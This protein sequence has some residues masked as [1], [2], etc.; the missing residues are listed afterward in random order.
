MKTRAR[1]V[2]GVLVLGLGIWAEAAI[3][4]ANE[5]PRPPLLG[6]LSTIPLSLGSWSG[7]DLEMDP[8]VLAESQAD[9]YIN[10]IYR[11][12][13]YPGVALRVWIN[14]SAHGLNMRHSPEICL[15]G[16]GYSKVESR[17]RVLEAPRAGGGVHR[18]SRLVYAQGEN[19]EGV[20]FWYDIYG[21]SEIEKA[22]RRLPLT[23]RSSHGRTTRGSGMTVE[24]FA[25]IDADPEGE[26]LVDF[27][28]ALLDALEPLLPLD[29]TSYHQ[30]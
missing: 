22:V 20:G 26:A 3:E 5:R 6:K 1:V 14:Y 15:P 7:H 2:A 11:N 25:P 10:R 12:P 18:L 27:S 8:G 23:N 16:H 29:R 21:E 9:D 19:F 4:A 13:A 17:C 28:A 24:I 30:P